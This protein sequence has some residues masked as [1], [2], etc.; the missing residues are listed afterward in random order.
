MLLCANEDKKQC[1][2]STKGI[3]NGHH[4]LKVLMSF[5]EPPGE[6]NKLVWLIELL[7]IH[8]LITHEQNLIDDF[9]HCSFMD[10]MT[11]EVRV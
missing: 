11:E 3:F 10:W 7:I 6:T 4:F 9:D 5:I 2:F 1:L 8:S